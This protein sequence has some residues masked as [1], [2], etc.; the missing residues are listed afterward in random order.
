VA[1]LIEYTKSHFDTEEN[2]LKEHGYKEFEHQK[3]SHEQF[4]ERTQQFQREL[5]EGKVLLTSE[6]MDFLKDW[7]MKHIQKEDMKY[8]DFFNAKGIY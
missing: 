6:M 5:L 8:R 3:Q 2:M 7:L 1:L 4:V